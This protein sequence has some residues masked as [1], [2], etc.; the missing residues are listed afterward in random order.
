M[1]NSLS[2]FTSVCSFNTSNK[3]GI[4]TDNPFPMK[5]PGLMGYLVLFLLALLPAPV[6]ITCNDINSYISSS[7]RHA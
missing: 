4:I 7:P 6:V 3:P 1:A 2:C 5:V